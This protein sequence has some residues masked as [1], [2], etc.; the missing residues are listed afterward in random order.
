MFSDRRHAGRQLGARLV[1]HAR[2]DSVV[3]AL[4]RGGVPVALEVARALEAD[5]DVLVVRK[6]GAPGNPEFAIGAVGEDGV[7]VV[8]DALRR[9]LNVSDADWESLVLAEREEVDRR[10]TSYR[11]DHAPVV[12]TGRPALIVDDG[13]ATGATAAAAVDVARALGA[14][15]V[16]VAVPVGSEGAVARIVA[17]ADDV[18][19][20]T[21][22]DPFWSVGENYRD[23]AQVSDA[24]VIAGL[25]QAG[26]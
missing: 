10:V 13:L 8:D 16:L 11:H 19:C 6:V 9:A 18:V 3:L 26:P 23:F 1:G 22:P 15:W 14:S 21:T 5:L 20:L 24:E 12:M 4:P 17:V 2:V 25:R 7:L